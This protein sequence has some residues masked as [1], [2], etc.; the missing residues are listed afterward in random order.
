MQDAQSAGF[1]AGGKLCRA[2]CAVL[3]MDHSAAFIH[4]KRQGRST[5]ALAL[6]VKACRLCQLPRGGSQPSQAHSVRQ[7]PPFVAARHLPPA[8]GSLSSRGELFAICR[9]AQ[10][11][12]PFR[13][14]WHRAAMTE[15]VRAAASAGSRRC[16]FRSPLRPLPVKKQTD[17]ARRLCRFANIKN[18]FS[19]NIVRA[20]RRQ[21][22]IVTS[23]SAVPPAHPGA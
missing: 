20:K 17:K 12:L 2:R 11:K 3:S 8:G 13:G 15:R 9:S 23:S 21:F 7:I 16:K 6:S 14:S 22:Q 18:N 4:I 5:T 1:S 10:I 19:S